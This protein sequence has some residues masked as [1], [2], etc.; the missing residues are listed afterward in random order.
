MTK[1]RPPVRGLVGFRFTTSDLLKG[2][3][4]DLIDRVGFKG[5]T[6]YIERHGAVLAKLVPSND[7]EAQVISDPYVDIH[8]RGVP[9]VKGAPPTS[10]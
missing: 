10:P 8:T 2:A 3:L 5:E 1:K 7:G 4:S 9:P 6:I